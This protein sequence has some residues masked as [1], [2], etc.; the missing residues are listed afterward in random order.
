MARQE[1]V[2]LTGDMD[3]AKAHETVMFGL[4]G[5]SYEIDLN[6]RKAAALRKSLSEF[7][8]GA[9][10]TRGPTSIAK[11]SIRGRRQAK[12]RAAGDPTGAQI[13]A[14]AATAGVVVS[15]RGRISAAVLQQFLTAQEGQHPAGS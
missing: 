7:V 10:P 9:R 2:A 14:W 11:P 3:G 1:T 4:D 6:S 8:A 5:V 12:R 13:R 15:Q